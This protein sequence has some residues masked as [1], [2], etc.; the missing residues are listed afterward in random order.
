MKK[1]FFSFLSLFE[2]FTYFI[3]YSFFSLPP[4]H[5]HYL[6]FDRF[7][8][9]KNLFEVFGYVEDF[10]DR[11]LLS[12]LNLKVLKEIDKAKKN[13]S[14]VVILS[15]S[16]SYLVEKIVKRLNVSAFKATSYGLD[17]KNRL[18]SIHNLMDGE[19]K[20]RYAVDLARSL[21]MPKKKISVY[22]DSIWD[23]PLLNIAGKKVVVSPD[24]GL[25]KIAKQKAWK[26]L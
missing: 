24:K 3:R 17:F 25:F 2:A 22:T 12:A 10:L 19:A 26:I 23:L 15:N 6:V 21:D 20:A 9:G 8:K 16:P 5:L 4:N 1:G 7:L 18:S 14:Y 11:Y 13:N